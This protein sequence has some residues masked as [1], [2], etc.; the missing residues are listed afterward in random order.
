MRSMRSLFKTAVY[1]IAT[2]VSTHDLVLPLRLT[3]VRP[4]DR[5][6]RP[7]RCTPPHAPPRPAHAKWYVSLV[8]LGR[9][10]T[11][12]CSS[13]LYAISQSAHCP[14]H[15]A[16]TDTDTVV[17]RGPYGVRPARPG[18]FCCRSCSTSADVRMRASQMLLALPV[19]LNSLATD[20]SSQ[21][22]QL[23]AHS[24]HC[25]RPAGTPSRLR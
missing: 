12:C 3:D 4:R 6:P 22:P 1:S 9:V 14:G 2:E 5:G 15:P 20:G 11:H 16:S 8:R 18:E 17:Q 19:V 24:A 13:S 23:C 21:V 10:L 7:N 25:P